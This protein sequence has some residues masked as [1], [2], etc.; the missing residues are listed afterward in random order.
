VDRVVLPTSELASWYRLKKAVAQVGEGEQFVLVMSGLAESR[1]KI[2]LERFA[3]NVRDYSIPDNAGNRWPES[4][5]LPGAPDAL[6]S[7]V[8]IQAILMQLKRQR[9][10]ASISYHAGTFLCNQTYYR[11]LH[12]WGNHPRCAGVLFVHLPAP[13]KYAT[14]KGGKPSPDEV[15]ESF[16]NALLT[17]AR[18]IALQAAHAGYKKGCQLRPAII[19][20]L[21]PDMLKPYWK[22]QSAGEDKTFGHCVHACE[23]LWHMLGG[24][25]STFRPRSVVDYDDD[26][27]LFL[28]CLM[29]GKILDPTRAQYKGEPIPYERSKGWG[30]STKLPSRK[31][32]VIIER[33]RQWMESGGQGTDE[34]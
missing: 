28:Q 22:E 11:A 7:P 26:K 3:L 1:E 4:P 14:L 30:F 25:L 13:Q 32:Q 20:A 2:S 16:A 27:H 18:S 24:P 8:D 12:R 21:T 15:I 33:A 29:T 19:A 31:A 9:L 23:A 6:K 34:P 5:I 10:R 17:S